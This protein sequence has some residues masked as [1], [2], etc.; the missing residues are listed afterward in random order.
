[1]RVDQLRALCAG[2]HETATDQLHIETAP[3]VI[4]VPRIGLSGPSVTCHAEAVTSFVP[5]RGLR[6]SPAAGPIR[7]LVSPPY[8]VF[9][10]AERARLAERSER[11]IVHVDYPLESDGPGRY[12]SAANLLAAWRAAGLVREDERESVYLYRMDFVDDLGNE[13]RTVGVMGGL[14]LADGDVLPHEQTTPKAKT[15]RLDLLESTGVNLSPIWGLSLARGLTAALEPAGTEL[16]D[17]TDE[18][19]VRHRLEAVDEPARVAGICGAVS[20]APVLIADGHHRLAVSRTYMNGAGAGR[21]GTAH[22]MTYVAELTESQLSIEAIHRLVAGAGIAEIRDALSAHYD[23][24]APITSDITG[25]GAGDVTVNEGTLREMRRT[26]AICLVGPGR[27]GTLM[28]LRDGA[29]VGTRPIDSARLEA[30]LE[31]LDVDVTYQHGVDETLARLDSGAHQA[32][33]LINPVS[34]ARIRE[35]A[36]TGQL[37]PPKSTFFTPKLLTGLVMRDTNLR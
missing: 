11:N 15:D 1:M 24:V 20:G 23:V 3:H 36:E 31:R 27:R 9:D 34:I 7:D 16:F 18:N 12:Q 19:G 2:R 5:F 21:P 14:G 22:A 37:M 6:Y 28:T 17:V 25:D 10:V 35:V 26:G 30:A 8:D 32:A 33:V 13:R 4:R 29:L